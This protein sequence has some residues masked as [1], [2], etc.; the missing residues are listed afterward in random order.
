[1]RLLPVF[2]GR[3]AAPPPSERLA[4]AATTSRPAAEQKMPRVTSFTTHQP[5]AL[6][7]FQDGALIEAGHQT[8]GSRHHLPASDIRKI[9]AAPSTATRVLL[10]ITLGTSAIGFARARRYDAYAF[11]HGTPPAFLSARPRR[12]SYGDR[13]RRL[14]P[15]DERAEFS[16]P[17]VAAGDEALAPDV[18]SPYRLVPVYYRARFICAGRGRHGRC[19]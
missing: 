15:F 19:R 5:A 17:L 16:L 12:A 18:D 9:A 10:A 4:N 3:W 8:E 1:M 7:L 13:R 2:L 14:L 11:R 6:H